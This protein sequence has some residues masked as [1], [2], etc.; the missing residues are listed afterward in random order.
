MNGY[1]IFKHGKWWR[2]LKSK[3][4]VEK[5][6]MYAVVRCESDFRTEFWTIGDGEP[7]FSNSDRQEQL[8]Q[9]RSVVAVPV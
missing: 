2:I 3:M 7:L 6:R 4:S 8:D 5:L 1:W 9:S